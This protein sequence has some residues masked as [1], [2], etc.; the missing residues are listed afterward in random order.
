MML[1]PSVPNYFSV[2]TQWTPALAA[3]IIV[4]IQNGKLEIQNIA[5]KTFIRLKYLQWY[6]IALIIP[7]TI[8]GMSYILL[9]IIDT[10]QWNEIKYDFHNESYFFY[11]L[12]MFLGCYGEEIGWRGFMLPLLRKKYSLFLSSLIIGV[13]W[14]LWHLYFKAGFSVFTVYMIM[15]IEI[16]FIISWITRRS[17]QQ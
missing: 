16:S 17:K 10:P 14:G 9:L 5:I 2:F 12:A 7:M 6:I 13:C 8:C 4:S 15:V 11:L 3:I 1:L